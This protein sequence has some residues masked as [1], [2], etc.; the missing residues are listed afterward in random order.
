MFSSLHSAVG[1][2]DSHP[3]KM[4]RLHTEYYLLQQSCV[5]IS[6]L[7]DEKTWTGLSF[8]SFCMFEAAAMCFYL[9]LNLATFHFDSFSETHGRFESP[10]HSSV[11]LLCF[12]VDMSVETSFTSLEFSFVFRWL[13]HPPVNI[14]EYNLSSPL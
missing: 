1:C 11:L 3:V 6:E 14:T 2:S 13:N 7:N 9:I 12:R 4:C 10:A 5:F 8:V